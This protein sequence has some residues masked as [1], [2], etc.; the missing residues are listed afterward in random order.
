M[1]FFY[2]L[3][4]LLS[5]ALMPTQAAINNKL[6]GEVGNPVLAAFISFG[7]GV[8]G[9]FAYILASGIPLQNLSAARNAPWIAWTGG[10]CGAFFVAATVFVVP[11]IGVALLF[12]ILVLG[13]MLASLP[14]DH[15]GFLGTEVREISVPRIIGVIL[16]VIGVFLVQKY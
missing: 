16:V 7:V 13:Q 4:A 12:G 3:L 6:S 14:I 11:R 8:I 2:Y 5:G 10:L 15:F 9:L 1:Q